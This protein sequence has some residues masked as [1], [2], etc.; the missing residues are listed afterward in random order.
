MRSA[1]AYKLRRREA[2]ASLRRVVVPMRL[3][4]IRA[5][6]AVIP[7]QAGIQLRETS[8][9]SGARWSDGGM[10]LVTA[11]QVPR[12]ACPPEIDLA[13]NEQ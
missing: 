9:N 11:R 3:M 10:A 7:A 4:V 5:Y 1:G 13:R 2:T 12:A 8:L 6:P